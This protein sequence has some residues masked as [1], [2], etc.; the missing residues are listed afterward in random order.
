MKVNKLRRLL[1]KADEVKPQNE[2]MLSEDAELDV[3][4][5]KLAVGALNSTV[6]EIFDLYKKLFEELNS[7]YDEYPSLYNEMKKIVR[8]PNENNA[9]DIVDMKKDLE[10][11]SSHYQDTKYLAQVI[12]VFKT[13][14]EA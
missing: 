5:A 4:G 7:L 11:L 1:K 10:Y 13:K 2:Q 3:E 8:F 6:D 14:P 9:Q 12:D